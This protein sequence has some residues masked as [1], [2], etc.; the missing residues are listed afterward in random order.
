MNMHVSNM[1]ERD[2]ETILEERVN[3]LARL[4]RTLHVMADQVFDEL[5]NLAKDM[6][7]VADAMMLVDAD[8]EVLEAMIS[9]ADI[10]ARD[11]RAAFYAAA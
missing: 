11:L 9:R 2:R 5:R 7:Q 4:A 1:I 3:D 10:Q 6:P 8:Q